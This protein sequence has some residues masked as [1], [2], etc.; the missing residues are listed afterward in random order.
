MQQSVSDSVSIRA[1]FF[2]PALSLVMKTTFSIRISVTSP[3][4]YNSHL[5]Q[6][7]SIDASAEC[8]IS[9]A[10]FLLLLIHVR[11]S[12]FYHLMFHI[13]ACGRLG[14]LRDFLISSLRVRYDERKQQHR[15]SSIYQGKRG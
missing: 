9:H 1:A 5:S 6:Y 4:R 12:L 7:L 13:L 15:L 10:F 11:L 14:F 8:I 3:V 2:T